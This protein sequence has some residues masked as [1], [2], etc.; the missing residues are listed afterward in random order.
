LFTAQLVTNPFYVSFRPAEHTKRGPYRLLPVEL[1][2]LNDLPV[3]VTPSRV[4]QPL[5]GTPAISAYFLD[6]NAYAREGDAF[7]VRGRS[8]ADVMLRAPI[9]IEVTPA[10]DVARSLR[11]TRLEVQLETGALANRVTVRTGRDT[12]TIEIPP[13]DAR[14][15]TLAMPPGLPYKPFPDLPTNYV[16]LLSVASE[17]GF[18]PL[19]ESGA[20]DARFLGV[21]VRLIPH[22]D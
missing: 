18:V 5:G 6:D 3:N 14:T 20:R 4:K 7:W 10:G 16:Y 11:V 17:S 13:N 2:L 19:F 9:V 21:F 1:S 15:L 8:R 12:Q 22:Y